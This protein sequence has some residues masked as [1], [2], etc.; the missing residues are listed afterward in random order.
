MASST[1][2]LHL[3]SSSRSVHDQRQRLCPGGQGSRTAD[4]RR[5]Q[6]LGKRSAGTARRVDTTRSCT[7]AF[8]S[9]ICQ[10]R[11][12]LRVTRFCAV[13][14]TGNSNGRFVNDSLR[15]VEKPLD[16]RHELAAYTCWRLWHRSEERRVGKECRS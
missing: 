16:G 10:A 7:I 4:A 9:S 1:G 5:F 11:K 14:A 8:P 15:L 6:C 2:P 3:L 12:I 13:A